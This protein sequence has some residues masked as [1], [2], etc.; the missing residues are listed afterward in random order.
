MKLEQTQ[1][2]FR[3]GDA[4]QT[5]FEVDRVDRGQC[6]E[7][8][9]SRLRHIGR[10]YQLHHWRYRGPTLDA[11]DFGMYRSKFW[12]KLH[13]MFGEGKIYQWSRRR[14]GFHGQLFWRQ[15]GIGTGRGGVRM[16]CLV[17]QRTDRS[18]ESSEETG[19]TSDEEMN[20]IEEMN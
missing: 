19:E 1:L 3:W 2:C 8:K 13:G 20:S 12:V 6:L 11:S 16:G 4:S 14:P 15:L 9:Q 18:D 10:E 17:F 7:W 5:L